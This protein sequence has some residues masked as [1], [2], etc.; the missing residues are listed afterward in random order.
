MQSKPDFEGAETVNRRAIVKME[1]AF[2][3][4]KMK[5]LFGNT[6]MAAEMALGLVS[7]AEGA[8]KPTFLYIVDI[9]AVS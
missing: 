8:A 9:I 2:F 3:Q 7:G 5:T 6:V 1:L 4:G